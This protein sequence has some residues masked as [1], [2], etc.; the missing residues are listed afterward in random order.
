MEISRRD[1]TKL[2]CFTLIMTTITMIVFS[3]SLVSAVFSESDPVC[4]GGQWE[5]YLC[6]TPYY[7]YLPYEDEPQFYCDTIGDQALMDMTRCNIG[8][9][10][11]PVGAD[12][13]LLSD[14]EKEEKEE[15]E[16]IVPEA[17]PLK[18]DPEEEGKFVVDE[19][20]AKLAVVK[21]ECLENSM[22]CGE[23]DEYDK[24]GDVYKCV[25]DT[26]QIYERC[27]DRTCEEKGA[28]YSR[29][30]IKWY[31][32]VSSINCYLMDKKDKNCYDTQE[33]C[34][35]KIGFCCY[36]SGTRGKSYI[37][38]EGQ[39]ASDEFFVQGTGIDFKK[40]ASYN[41]EPSKACAYEYACSWYDLPCYIDTWFGKQ[42]CKVKLMVSNFYQAYKW[43]LWGIG[44]LL[45]L[46]FLQFIGVLPILILMIKGM[47]GGLAKL[48]SKLVS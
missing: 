25:D 15:E 9:F 20:K 6:N 36:K 30:A 27:E 46:G 22:K 21:Y 1:M 19:E 13:C 18:E 40:C 33:E 16:V 23:G 5:G 43:W 32:C 2:V 38:R 10:N 44:T 48:F 39:C 45:V 8:C 7:R 31:Y 29:C 42:W 17:P 4:M 34:E 35:S 37:W 41:T 28:Y 14:E 11:N 3:I 12:F 24:G 47:M 26:W